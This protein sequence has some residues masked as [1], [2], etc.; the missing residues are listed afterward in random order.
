M[1]PG[2]ASSTARKRRRRSSR[3]ADTPGARRAAVLFRRPDGRRGR[4]QL[5]HPGRAG[6]SARHGRH[7]A[8]AVS[9]AQRRHPGIDDLQSSSFA[10]LTAGGVEC[11][12]TIPG[13]G[14]IPVYVP[15][16]YWPAM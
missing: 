8:G 9:R 5:D 13:E 10:G 2:S 4:V 16:F 15:Y 1:K 7:I 11:N 12:S 3:N 14:A 6:R